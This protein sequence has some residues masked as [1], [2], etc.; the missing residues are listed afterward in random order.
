MECASPS[1]LIFNHTIKYIQKLSFLTPPQLLLLFISCICDVMA[2][3]RTW[4][5]NYIA[6]FHSR[7]QRFKLSKIH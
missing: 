7:K 2:A 6:L 5:R 4:A 3:T 1:K